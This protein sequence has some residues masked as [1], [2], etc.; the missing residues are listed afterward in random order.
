MSIWRIIGAANNRILDFRFSILD[1]EG[2][3]Q[4]FTVSHFFARTSASMAT[5]VAESLIRQSKIQNRK[6]KIGTGRLR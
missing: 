1:E 3:M 4:V 2:E 5:A 6:S